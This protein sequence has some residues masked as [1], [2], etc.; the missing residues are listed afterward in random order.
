MQEQPQDIVTREL[1]LL[2]YERN[3]VAHAR[4]FLRFKVVD[5]LK[6]KIGPVISWWEDFDAENECLFQCK[7]NNLY[8]LPSSIKVKMLMRASF[9]AS[10]KNII[11]FLVCYL[12]QIILNL[13]LVNIL[14]MLPMSKILPPLHYLDNI[15]NTEECSWTTCFVI[16][17]KPNNVGM[18]VI[19]KIWS[20]TLAVEKVMLSIKVS[21]C[22]FRLLCNISFLNVFTF[23]SLDYN[24]LQKCIIS[25]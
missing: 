25:L 12:V 21:T 15:W 20:I 19:V 10:L 1:F 18:H 6:I 5:S 7:N 24:M 2:C 13:N 11:F 3:K 23:R 8:D 22:Q 16:L 4:S 9:E 14:C 17:Q